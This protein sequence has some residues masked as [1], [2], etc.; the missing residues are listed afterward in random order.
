[1]YIP[2][3]QH[4]FCPKNGISSPKN[5]PEKKKEKNI[6][7]SKLPRVRDKPS[8]SAVHIPGSNIGKL[9]QRRIREIRPIF[10][11]R[12]ILSPRKVYATNYA[13]G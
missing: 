13:N 7:Y 9:I 8:R 11:A 1:M 4:S 10:A 6:C 5:C 2:R 12:P 3:E